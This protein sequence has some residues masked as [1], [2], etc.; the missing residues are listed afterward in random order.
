MFC[1]VFKA[2]ASSS[3]N[4]A[5][6]RKYNRGSSKKACNAGCL[7]M[8]FDAW[9]TGWN[10]RWHLLVGQR[11]DVMS[12][13]VPPYGA[14]WTSGGGVSD[15]SQSKH[16]IP[17]GLHAWCFSADPEKKSLKF[18]VKISDTAAPSNTLHAGFHWCRGIALKSNARKKH[19]L[20]IYRGNTSSATCYN[21]GLIS[22]L[23]TALLEG[24][25]CITESG[26][27]SC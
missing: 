23:K 16:G 22:N 7:R 9:I 15:R 26:P 3:K 21:G 20:G 17:G 6:L 27:C 14:W 5:K 2:N 24:A 8:C 18:G 11:K 10:W 25:L 1:F 12:L 19:V 4:K 13:L